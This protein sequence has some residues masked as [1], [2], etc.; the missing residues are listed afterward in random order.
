LAWCGGQ[1]NPGRA[2][3][4][5]PGPADAMTEKGDMEYPLA[6]MVVFTEH[7]DLIRRGGVASTIK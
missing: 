4:L 3:L 2:A 5:T 7:E 6:K 1:T